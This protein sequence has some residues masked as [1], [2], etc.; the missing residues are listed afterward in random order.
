MSVVPSLLGE[1]LWVAL[2]AGAVMGLWHLVSI[3]DFH[4]LSHPLISLYIARE[5]TVLSYK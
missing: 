1:R 2:L 5:V 3:R 4:Y